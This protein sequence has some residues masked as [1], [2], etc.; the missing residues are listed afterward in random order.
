MEGENLQELVKKQA[1]I[2]KRQEAEIADLKARIVELKTII[3]HLQKNSGNSS[4]P[5]SS[6]IVKPKTQA[7]KQDGGTKR[8]I[9]GQRGHKKHERTPFAPEEVDLSIEATLDACPLCGGALQECEKETIVHQQIDIAP[10][11]FIVTEYHR[12]TYWCPA[13]QTVHTAS[14]PEAA[15]SGL[16]SINLIAFVAYLKGR[17]HISFSALK[18]FFLEVMGIRISRGFLAKQVQKASGSLKGIHSSW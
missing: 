14:L 12:H 17:C 9:G 18:D 1:E 2:I 5:P 7:Q 16:F 6:D 13:C 15:R 10:K 4:K 11:P 8:K 3:A